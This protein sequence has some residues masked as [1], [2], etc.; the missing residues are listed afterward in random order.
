VIKV[1]LVEKRKPVG[2]FENVGSVC[3]LA[4]FTV[5]C[6]HLNDVNGEQKKI[7]GAQ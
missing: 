6:G 5:I 3:G 4:F 2:N 7:K 1:F